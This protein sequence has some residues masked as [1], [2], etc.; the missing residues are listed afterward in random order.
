[1]PQACRAGIHSNQQIRGGSIQE[2]SSDGDFD[3][4]T[5]ISSKSGNTSRNTSSGQRRDAREVHCL[6]ACSPASTPTPTIYLIWLHYQNNTKALG[7]RVW[8]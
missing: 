3:G 5:G 1:M 4:G 7:E 2:M 8:V 6:V